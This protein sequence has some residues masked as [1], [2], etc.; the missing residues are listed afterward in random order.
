MDPL[1]G[2]A[3]DLLVGVAVGTEVR[4]TLLLIVTSDH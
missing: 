4:N 2:V 3:V 1:V